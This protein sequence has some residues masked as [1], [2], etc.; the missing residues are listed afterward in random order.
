MHAARRRRSVHLRGRGKELAEVGDEPP[1]EWVLVFAASIVPEVPVSVP[2]DRLVDGEICRRA[3]EGAA[4]KEQG[5]EAAC[6]LHEGQ[7]HGGGRVAAGRRP[8]RPR[9]CE[10][11]P[12]GG[13]GGPGA[14]EVA[15]APAQVDEGVLPG[16]EGDEEAQKIPLVAEPHA[17]VHE[18]AVVVHPPHA[19]L[20]VAA[21]LGADGARHAARLA[22]RRAL[23]GEHLALLRL[24]VQGDVARVGC[25]GQPEERRGYNEVQREEGGEKGGARPRGRDRPEHV[26]EE[27]RPGHENHS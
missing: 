8:R 2:V 12:R 19:A 9:A 25:N 13:P 14:H 4:G 24:P 21:V 16:E 3:Q 18:G 20:A 1:V 7:E 10:D 23:A 27:V 5:E 11:T 6:G 26:H 15:V 17:V 22:Q